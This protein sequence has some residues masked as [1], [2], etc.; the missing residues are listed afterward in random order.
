MLSQPLEGSPFSVSAN[1]SIEGTFSWCDG[2]P[3]KIYFSY[4]GELEVG[5]VP[6]DEGADQPLLQ[7][8]R[9]PAP[10]GA[11]RQALLHR[12]LVRPLPDEQEHEHQVTCNP[13]APR[14]ILCCQ[15]LRREQNGTLATLQHVFWT[16]KYCNIH[17]HILSL[18]S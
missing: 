12:R 1:L 9:Q 6:G 3:L 5:S 10:R 16:A 2:I 11:L 4:T 13:W 15:R 8:G 17:L 14:Q 18:S 7:D